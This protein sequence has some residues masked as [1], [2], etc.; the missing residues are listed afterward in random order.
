MP[1]PEIVPAPEPVADVEPEPVPVLVVEVEPEPDVENNNIAIIRK[2]DINGVYRVW[3]NWSTPDECPAEIRPDCE[4]WLWMIVALEVR[5]LGVDGAIGY[6]TYLHGEQVQ[7]LIVD[8]FP[9]YV[10]DYSYQVLRKIKPTGD[11]IED[12]VAINALLEISGYQVEAWSAD[13]S[14]GLSD[15]GHLGTGHS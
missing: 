4:P 13:F 7:N 9:S 11:A 10:N 14:S 1:D 15:L 6:S 2:P 8:D 12:R 5:R 3:E